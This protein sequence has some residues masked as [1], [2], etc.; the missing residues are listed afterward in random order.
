MSSLPTLLTLSQNAFYEGDTVA[1]A[2]QM[3]GMVLQIKGVGKKQ[4]AKKNLPYL[5]PWYRIVET[6]AYTQN[7]PSCHAYKRKSGRALNMYRG[8]G[9]AYVY[10]TYGMYH[11]L[12]VVTEPEGVAGAV[13]IRALEPLKI[14]EDRL[15]SMYPDV[16]EGMTKTAFKKLMQTN[17]P[18]KLCRALTIHRDMH[19]ALT[20]TEPTNP[21][22]LYHDDQIT[23]KPRDIVTT[24]RIGISKA[25][26]YPW[27]FYVNDNVWVSKK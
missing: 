13:L 2:K 9:T 25:Q 22:L 3:L 17:G 14:K 11:C 23:L 10:F 15:V 12:N 19:N 6:E 16:P 24:T 8:P 1:V 21:L 20:V 5:T 18:G 26:D 4:I 27:R 7:D